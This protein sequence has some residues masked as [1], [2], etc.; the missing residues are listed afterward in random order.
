M[1]RSDEE[2]NFMPEVRGQTKRNPAQADELAIVT[3]D[4]IIPQYPVKTIGDEPWLGNN[5]VLYE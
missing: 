2:E 5:G 4:R 3:R 1:R